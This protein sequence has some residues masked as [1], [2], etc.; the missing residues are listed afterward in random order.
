MV[1]RPMSQRVVLRKKA[2]ARIRSPLSHFVLVGLAFFV[3]RGLWVATPDRMTIEVRR[4]D[5]AET[6][7][8]FESQVGRTASPQEKRALESQIIEK[9]L[10]LAQAKAL[11]LHHSD[12]VVRRRLIQ[13]MRFLEATQTH[14]SDNVLLERAFELE[15]E[16]SDP[17]S[18]RRLVD[19]VKALLEAGVRSERPSES[20]LRTFY[21]ENAERWTEAP[22]LDFSH[23][24][25]SRD[26]RR[27]RTAAD[28]D[29]V[30]QH[31]TDEGA[32]LEAATR[33]GDPF[34]SGHD[35]RNASPTQIVA[36]LGP[37]FGAEIQN[38]AIMQWTQPIESVFGVHLVWIHKRVDA[39]VSPYA[40]VRMR[41]LEDWY[42]EET[43][44]T[45][46]REITR[47]RARV[48]IRMLDG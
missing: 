13:N 24:F 42:E 14:E 37:A 35:L 3:I 43:R 11:G 12:P 4:S 25:F 21:Q 44:Q 46:Q 38:V 31:L 45:Q 2:A 36:R 40:E 30:F 5:I 39:R 10:W 33:R 22:R 47:H 8:A 19:R 32:F 26:K 7:S 41:V 23:V 28:A 20:D 48:E 15:M 18:Q 9:R 17:V 27:E 34:L 6:V 1:N 16:S 29:V